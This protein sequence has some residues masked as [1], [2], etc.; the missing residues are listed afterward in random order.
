MI[1]F[2]LKA[3]F[4]YGQTFIGLPKGLANAQRS[5]S[6]LTTDGLLTETRIQQMCQTLSRQPSYQDIFLSRSVPLHGLCTIHFSQFAPRHRNLS[7]GCWAQ[8]I[9]FRIQRQ[10]CKKHSRRNQRKTILA[11]ICRFRTG[12]DPISSTSP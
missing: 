7:T 12:S 6:I 4:S 10:S 3:F 8:V 9:P 5:I 2:D 1:V 11:N